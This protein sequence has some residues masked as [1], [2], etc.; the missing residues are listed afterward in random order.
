MIHYHVHY[1]VHFQAYERFTAWLREESIPEMLKQP[2]FTGAELLLNKGGALVSSGKD[3]KVVFRLQ[4]E[5]ALKTY[6]ASAMDIRQ[7]AVDKF[8]GEFSAHREVWMESISF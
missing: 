3:V 1:H 7:K 8:P 2:G 4:N 6:L 5:T